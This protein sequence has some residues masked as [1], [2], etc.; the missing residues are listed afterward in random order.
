[1]RRLS[2][3]G[4]ALSFSTAVP[5]LVACSP[6]RP[7]S[8]VLV[9]VDTLRADH[10]G[11]YGY[12]RPTSPSF[13]AWA[14]AGRLFEEAHSTSPWTLPSVASILTG[15][16]PARHGAGRREE[17]EKRA[18]TGLGT[19]VSTLA[20]RLSDAGWKT[21]AIVNNPFLHEKF[22]VSRGFGSWDYHSANRSQ[23][24]R[25]DASVDAALAWLDGVGDV[26]F[27]LFLHVIDPHLAYDAPA[28]FLGRFSDG[29]PS[30]MRRRRLS[31]IREQVRRDDAFDFAPLIAAYDEEVL[32]VDAQLGRLRRGLEER[33]LDGRTLVVVTSD[34]GEEFGDHGGFE[35]GHSVHE[36][37][38]HVPLLLVGPGVDA[39]RTSAPVTLLDVAPTILEALGVGLGSELPGS[40]LLAEPPTGRTLVAERTLYGDEEKAA[41]RWP[42]KLLWTPESGTLALFD[43]DADP[44]E[45]RDRLPEEPAIAERLHEL[46]EAL[47]ALEAQEP[48]GS[49][50]LDADT[51]RELRS[52]GYID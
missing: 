1:M 4:L 43:L 21:G 36:E 49:A 8:V 44:G 7:D 29:A 35:H 28:P 3:L 27:F 33:A 31:W 15:L 14:A 20:A 32:F 5:L 50:V 48:G 45:L 25:A 24:R 37:L 23:G 18:F 17:G 2:A 6:D 41:I 12:P 16:E 40:S 11:A 34:H 51:E 22:G 19:D 38:L 10:L 9:V 39:G 13:D 42:W 46:L 47:A 52:L 26:P 30:P